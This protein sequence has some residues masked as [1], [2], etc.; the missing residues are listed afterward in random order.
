MGPKSQD[1]QHWDCNVQ[2]GGVFLL[3]LSR[4][5]RRGVFTPHG[6]RCTRPRNLPRAVQLLTI[7]HA[8]SAWAE[9]R[10]QGSAGVPS[11]RL[12]VDPPGSRFS[13]PHPPTGLAPH[14]VPTCLHLVCCV[15]V[16]TTSRTGHLQAKSRL[17]LHSHTTCLLPILTH[18]G[19]FRR[20]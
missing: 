4:N 18:K 5:R 14:P 19:L 10:A 2:D 3:T 9:P 17:N 8:R 13:A 6:T 12:P 11:G 7:A 16:A 20:Y 15:P 1:P